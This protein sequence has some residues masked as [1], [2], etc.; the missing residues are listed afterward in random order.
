MALLATEQHCACLLS[1]SSF[2]LGAKCLGDAFYIRRQKINVK[3]QSE[4]LGGKE[5]YFIYGF[6]IFVAYLSFI[7]SFTI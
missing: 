6:P 5:D 2:A 7:I 4:R 3:Q 1:G